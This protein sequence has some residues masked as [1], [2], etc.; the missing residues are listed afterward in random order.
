LIIINLLAAG[1]PDDL[2]AATDV[3]IE[4]RDSAVPLAIGLVDGDA[5]DHRQ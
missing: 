3:L 4:P 2:E 1:I 5:G